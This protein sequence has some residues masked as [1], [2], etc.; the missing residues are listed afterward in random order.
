MTC[1]YCGSGIQ[2]RDDLN[3]DHVVPAS[4]GGSN[5]DHNLVVACKAC[6]MK[7]SDRVWVPKNIDAIAKIDGVHADAIRAYAMLDSSRPEGSSPVVN[8]RAGRPPKD[9]ESGKRWNIYCTKS[10]RDLLGQVMK[11]TPDQKEFIRLWIEKGATVK[12]KGKQ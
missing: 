5:A 3:F 12:Y 1:Q 11:L 2:A 9:G 4:R 10:T 6:N 7:K 8:V